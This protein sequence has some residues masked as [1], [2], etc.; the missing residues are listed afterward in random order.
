[1]LH[2]A[3][4]IYHVTW[5]YMLIKSHYIRSIGTSC[6]WLPR[7]S[8]PSSTTWRTLKARAPPTAPGG[9]A[10]AAPGCW[11]AGTCSPHPARTCTTPRA[12]C[13]PSCHAARPSRAAVLTRTAW[14]PGLT[15]ASR[16]RPADQSNQ[17]VQGRAPGRCPCMN[18]P[19][20]RRV[21]PTDSLRQV[22][23][24]RPGPHPTCV[25]I[26]PCTARICLPTIAAAGIQLN[27]CAHSRALASCGL[28]Y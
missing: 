11:S 28:P 15:I 13:L 14:R 22:R 24:S 2:A 8:N 18:V 10:P 16:S 12:H 25:P 9:L 1:M 3:H 21:Y 5:C 20:E 23:S 7:N 19:S 17:P 6:L 27:T 4:S 26:P